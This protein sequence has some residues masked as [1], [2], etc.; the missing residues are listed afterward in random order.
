[1]KLPIPQRGQPL[2]VTFV[3]DIVS[4]V[5]DLYNQI[6]IK[7][8]AYASL[9]TSKGRRQLRSTEIKFYTNQIS[10][11]A[12][13]K[14]AGSTIDFSGSFDVGFADT[15]IILVTPVGNSAAAKQSYATITT[16]TNSS[17]TG[18]LLINKKGTEDIK[19]NILAIGI[20][21]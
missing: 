8:S 14:A 20:P 10:V 15:P 18:T 12:K 2:D 7:V 6:A 4:S 9:W 11:A 5:N 17:F 3:S 1:M 21:T 19:I 16:Y 13:D